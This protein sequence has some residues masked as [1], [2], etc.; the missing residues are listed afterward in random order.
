MKKCNQPIII[1]GMHR[2][3]TS[4]ITRFIEDSGVF[5]GK[6]NKMD[7][8]SEALFFQK[9]NAWLLYQKGASWDSTNNLNF[10][11]KFTHDNLVKVVKNR[12]KSIIHTRNFLDF[13]N[14]FLN[15]NLLDCNFTWGWKDPRNTLLLDVWSEIF[16][17]AKIIHIYR[18]PIDV[19]N[20]LV[21]REKRLENKFKIN[22]RVLKH[23]FLL[24]KKPI[25]N[26]SVRITNIDEGIKLWEDYVNFSL[27]SEKYFKNVIHIGYENFLLNPKINLKK[28]SNFLGIIDDENVIESIISKVNPKRAYAFKTNYELVK[29]YKNIKDRSLM[30]KLNYNNLL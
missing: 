30:K 25:Y 22:L 24:T 1:I 21:Q 7:S 8:N 4:M 15:G 2:S 23:E 9:I 16:P 28:L 13:K 11:N 3:G 5:I 18:N 6:K 17:N 29:I 27:N 14:S 20:S 26:Q 10:N 19:A 12:L